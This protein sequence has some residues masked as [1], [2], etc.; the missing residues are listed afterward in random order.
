[1]S[2]NETASPAL[3]ARDRI[4]IL[5][6]GNGA[7]AKHRVLRLVDPARARAFRAECLSAELERPGGDDGAGVVPGAR[8]Q[9][10]EAGPALST[11]R[12]LNRLFF[13]VDSSCR[14]RLQSS[15]YARN[16]APRAAKA[17]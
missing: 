14:V 11:R 5:V 12:R 13:G 16:E 3:A 4:D 17:A 6:L 2:L 9:S 7:A 1:M 15:T 10:N 8:P